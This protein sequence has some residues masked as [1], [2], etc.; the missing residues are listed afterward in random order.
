MPRAR[1]SLTDTAITLASILSPASY[2]SL[3]DARRELG[4]RNGGVEYAAE[5]LLGHGITVYWHDNGL[6]VDRDSW[7][8]CQRI[9]AMA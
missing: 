1:S 6:I 9:G 2:L 3:E 5:Q 8:A 7:A 4:N